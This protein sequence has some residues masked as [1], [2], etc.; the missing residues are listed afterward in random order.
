MAEASEASA[1]ASAPAATGTALRPPPPTFIAPSEDPNLEMIYSCRRCR[2]LLFRPELITEHDTAQHRFSSHRRAKDIASHD[3]NMAY[4]GPKDCT[5]F[6]L[7]EAVQ[8]MKS[9]SEDVEGKLCCPKCNTRLGMLKW[10]GSQC[11]CGTWV[12]PAIQVYKKSV[13]ERYVP[14]AVPAATPAATTSSSGGAGGGAAV[15]T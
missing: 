3:G 15:S 10:A 11:S 9:A 13:D 1:A 4:G 5:S 8:W 14:K 6:F 12:T 2:Q 7:A